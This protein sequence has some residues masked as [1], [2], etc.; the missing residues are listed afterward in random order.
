MFTFSSPVKKY[1]VIAVVTIAAVLLFMRHS[2]MVILKGNAR[3]R[4]CEARLVELKQKQDLLQRDIVRL[5]SDRRYIERIARD[6][7]G[8]TYPDEMIYTFSDSSSKDDWSDD[9]KE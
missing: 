1:L 5:K 9:K 2:I 4:E 8:L 6:Q 3:R 7:L